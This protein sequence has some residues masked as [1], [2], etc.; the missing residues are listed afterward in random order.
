MHLLAGLADADSC[1]TACWDVTSNI[2]CIQWDRIVEG[3]ET[4]GCSL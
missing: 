1:S 2:N 3:E 4:D